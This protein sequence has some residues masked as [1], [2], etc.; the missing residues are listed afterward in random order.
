M[1][2]LNEG[3]EDQKE[4]GGNHPREA[5]AGRR[6]SRIEAHQHWPLQVQDAQD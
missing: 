4:A 6:G 1:P 2:T 3:R 5:Q